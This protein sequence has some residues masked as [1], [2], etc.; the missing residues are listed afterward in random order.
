[1]HILD[2]TW[3]YKPFGSTKISTF[4]FSKPRFFV[5]TKHCKTL[6]FQKCKLGYR[7]FFLQ[8]IKKHQNDN[9]FYQNTSFIPSPCI[10]LP[11]FSQSV[12]TPP[13][14]YATLFSQ[15]P[16]ALFC[17]VSGLHSSSR[18]PGNNSPFL[19]YWIYVID[20][21]FLH[22]GLHIV[23]NLNARTYFNWKIYCCCCFCFWV[24]DLFGFLAAFWDLP[25]LGFDYNYCFICRHIDIIGISFFFLVGWE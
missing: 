8:K 22:G 14:I 3:F 18:L 9:R 13:C 20:L 15:S 7:Y 11:L 25:I 4:A 24:V 2:K 12:Y 19:F 17:F 16:R 1:M 23:S 21:G 5:F 6:L 10:S